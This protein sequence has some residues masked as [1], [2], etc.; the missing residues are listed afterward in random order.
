[1]FACGEPAPAPTPVPEQREARQA[2]PA[3]PPSRATPPPPTPPP[4]EPKSSDPP[5]PI[6][7]SDR[8]KR[9]LRDV[10]YIQGIKSACLEVLT[11]GERREPETSYCFCISVASGGAKISE[12]DAKWFFENF[13]TQARDEMARRYPSLA[14][15]Y[16]S[17]QAQREAYSPD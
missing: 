1:M 17:C 16:A 4:A 14:R 8:P 6:T 2:P 15:M 12:A 9:I 10:S 7:E 5:A 3:S 13:S 11:G